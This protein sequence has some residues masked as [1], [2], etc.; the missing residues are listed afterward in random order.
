MHT[1]LGSLSGK[2]I[3]GLLELLSKLFMFYAWPK[4]AL[5]EYHPFG[6]NTEQINL[7]NLSRRNID[8]GERMF[9]WSLT[10]FLTPLPTYEEAQNGSPASALKAERQATQDAE[11]DDNR[12]ENRNGVFLTNT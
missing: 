2:S 8:V 1:V 10:R 7:Y 5:Q 4:M 9:S 6:V 3:I 12:S 11:N